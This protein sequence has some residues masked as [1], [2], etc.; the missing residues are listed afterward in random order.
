[1]ATWQELYPSN[2]DSD[3][4]HVQNGGATNAD[5]SW[6][7]GYDNSTEYYS[8]GGSS[9]D[10]TSS[11]STSSDSTSSGNPTQEQLKEYQSTWGDTTTSFEDAAGPSYEEQLA[12]EIVRA[13]SDGIS[14]ENLESTL[15]LPN[16]TLDGVRQELSNMVSGGS[17][18]DV[19]TNEPATN[20]PAVPSILPENW[21]SLFD[22]Q[23]QG[24][25]DSGSGL[26][27]AG[28]LAVGV[29]LSVLGGR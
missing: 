29:V 11:D 5:E 4:N 27:V 23:G 10:S 14:R 8:S 9:S 18:S 7:D 21:P 13:G 25:T 2:Y 20:E 24:Q 16:T 12:S 1:M 19:P 6:N 15:S 28:V 17:E 22:G 26:L 3:G